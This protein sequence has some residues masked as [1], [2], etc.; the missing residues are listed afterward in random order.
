MR[1]E[2]SSIVSEVKATVDD[3]I[4][5]RYFTKQP[6][7]SVHPLIANDIHVDIAPS[8]KVRVCCCNITGK[9]A[10]TDGLHFNHQ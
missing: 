10:C 1:A 7:S 8:L 2:S 6:H 3:A 4:H 9:T 5:F